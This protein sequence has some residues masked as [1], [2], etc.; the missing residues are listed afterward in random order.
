MA[1]GGHHPVDV[2]GRHPEVRDGTDLAVR[3]GD[4]PHASR[5]EGGEERGPIAIDTEQHEVGEP[6]AGIQRPVLV[7]LGDPAGRP[8]AGQLREPFGQATGVGVVLGQAADGPVR[9]VRERDEPGRR[10]HAHLA[11]PAAEELARAARASDERAR[12]DD[13]RADRGAEALGQAERDAVRGRGQGRGAHPERDS[14]IEQPG[15]VDVEGD[16]PLVGDRGHLLHVV[17]RERPAA[18]VGVRVLKD[19]QPGDGLVDVLGV[20]PG[21]RDLGQVHGSVRALLEGTDRGAHDD[22][23]PA[24]LVHDGVGRRAGDGLV[25]AREV[26]DQRHEVAHGA[27]RDEQA[28]FL[29]QQLRG[30]RLELVDG[31]I[32]AEHVIA[33]ARGG[34]RAAHG[35][36]RVGDGVGAQVDHGRHGPA[37]ISRVSFGGARR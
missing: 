2:L 16:P 7:R 37:S 30:P 9:A 24:G 18:G 1:S 26:R 25:A 21:V 23:V 22:G 32:V 3:V 5:L 27:A 17:E 10:E 13:H 33:D 6:A 29:A 4:H 11:H 12:A 35:V 15:A 31:G 36:G 19:H 34:H 14:G 28:R 8:D 20:A